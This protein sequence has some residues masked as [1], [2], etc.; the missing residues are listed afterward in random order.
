MSHRD[1]AD[2]LDGVD[3]L[4]GLSVLWVLLHHIHLR[5]YL[6]DYPVQH[7][8]P[9]ALN[10]ALFWSGYYAV[11]IFF[12]ISGFLITSL[13]IK[14]WVTL[15]QIPIAAF[16][17][18][19][20][21]RIVPCLLLLLTII[22]ALHLAGAPEFVIDPERASLGRALVAALTVH[23]NWLEGHHGYLPGCWDVLWSL[24]IEEAFYLA[25]PLVCVFLRRERALLPLLLALIFA[26]AINRTWISDDNDPWHDYAYLSCMDGIAFGCLAALAGAR[27]KMTTRMLR[28]A[29]LL[30]T[31]LVALIVLARPLSTLLHLDRLG[32]NVTL[33]EAGVALMLLAFGQGVGNRA[34]SRG[35]G[36]LRWMGR[37]SYEV[38]LFHM[39][40]VLAL[41]ALIKR[42]HA[43]NGWIALSYAAMALLSLAVGYTVFRFYS[44]PLNRALRGRWRQPS[45]QLDQSAV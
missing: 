13:S 11:I 23:L 30:G 34:V 27:L 15:G 45:V 16:Y 39:I 21:A 40:V 41:I 25:F 10:T 6:N 29:L 4:R 36:W 5:F 22:S 19:R 43:P 37:C 44:E 33:L 1:H 14:R 7:V 42:M 2:R 3:L 17:R 18:L 31:A 35:T 28:T 8:L 12:V 24:S 26:G 9:H 20:A 32:L 38:Y